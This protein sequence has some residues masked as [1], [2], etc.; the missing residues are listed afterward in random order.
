[1]ISLLLAIV[2]AQEPKL[3]ED[4][5]SQVDI[6]FID[7]LDREITLMVDFPKIES[8]NDVAFEVIK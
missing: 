4:E 1:M 7:T 5:L 8:I 2:I 6:D 3:N